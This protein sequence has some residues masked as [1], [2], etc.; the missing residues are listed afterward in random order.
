MEHGQLEGQNYRHREFLDFECMG[1][2]AGEL[3]FLFF[4]DR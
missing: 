3:E 1:L 4:W 2:A